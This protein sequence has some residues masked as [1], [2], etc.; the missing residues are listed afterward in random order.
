MIHKHT[1]IGETGLKEAQANINNVMLVER[2][3]VSYG[4]G[5]IRK[6]RIGVMGGRES[7]W[8][9]FPY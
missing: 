8:G 5:Q 7:S 2:M 6:S 9:M 3:R 1:K 4:N